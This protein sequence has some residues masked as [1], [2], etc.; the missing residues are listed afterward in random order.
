MNVRYGRNINYVVPQIISGKEPEEI[1]FYLRVNEVERN[2]RILAK[3]DEDILY[4]KME[5]IVKP[6]EMVKARIAS[7]GLHGLGNELTIGVEP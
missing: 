4:E 2:V 6:P 7:R 1:T 3:S 5:I